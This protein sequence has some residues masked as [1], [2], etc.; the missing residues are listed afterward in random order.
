MDLVK[1]I[2]KEIGGVHA[3]ICNSTKVQP[4]VQCFLSLRRKGTLVAIGLPVTDL[5]IPIF[6]LI[7]KEI[8]VRGSFVGSRND[9]E[10]AYQTATR[11]GIHLD[12]EEAPLEEVNEVFRRI[13]EGK[14]SSRILLKPV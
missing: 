10:A 8:T 1:Y 11:V 4:F 9:L 3:A 5:P 6:S 7:M 13:R 12:S 2:R 14:T